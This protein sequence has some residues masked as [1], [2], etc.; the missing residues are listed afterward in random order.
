MSHFSV[1]VATQ[2]GTQAELEKAL[3]PYREFEC[4][5]Q[6]DEYVLSIDITKE[7]LEDWQQNSRLSLEEYTGYSNY[8]VLE[9]DPDLENKHKWGWIE[10]NSNGDVAKVIRRTNPNA[11]WDWWTVGGR[12]SGKLLNKSGAR[13]DSARKNEI[14][15]D[16]MQQTAGAK[17]SAS[18]DK[19]HG[20]FGK[21]LASF[22]PWQRVLDSFDTIPQARSYYHSQDFVKAVNNLNI[23][24]PYP[25]Q[26]YLLDRE[27]FV[28]KAA[29]LAIDFYAVLTDRWY[30]QGDMGWWGLSKNT[31][32]NWQQVR[33]EVLAAVPDTHYLTVIDCHI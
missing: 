14:D 12:M 28:A 31:I 32:D 9:G 23:D 16:K 27:V 20:D 25:L 17:A 1:L 11:K 24:L 5:G 30:G 3:Q 7:T 22:K 6:I 2:N 18:W 21:E 10:L 4:T 15:F 33:T 26:E 13:V 29:D 8:S 19:L